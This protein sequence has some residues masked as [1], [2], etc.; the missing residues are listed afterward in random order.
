M[1][2]KNDDGAKDG[3]GAM[4]MEVDGLVVQGPVPVK[5]QQAPDVRRLEGIVG[6]KGRGKGEVVSE[7]SMPKG[8]EENG[9]SAMLENEQTLGVATAPAA[10]QISEQ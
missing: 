2:E 6:G 1:A 10:A 5:V 3:G 4:P 8:S 9:R 7:V